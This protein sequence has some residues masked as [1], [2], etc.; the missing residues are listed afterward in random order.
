MLSD[1]G[2]VCGLV[3]G[4]KRALVG[5][6]LTWGHHINFSSLYCFLCDSE[7]LWHT[8]VA[9]GR[10]PAIKLPVDSRLRFAAPYSTFGLRMSHYFLFFAG[11]RFSHFQYP[12]KTQDDSETNTRG[13]DPASLFL[14]S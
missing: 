14:L 11:S 10:C 8:R 3:G 13:N 7:A 5:G 6:V 1:M 4:G 9:A 12:I 2:I